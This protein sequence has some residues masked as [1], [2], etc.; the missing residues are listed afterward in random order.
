MKSKNISVSLEYHQNSPEFLDGSTVPELDTDVSCRNPDGRECR[1]FCDLVLES[2]P[3]QVRHTF[4]DLLR[5]FLLRKIRIVLAATHPV[6]ECRWRN[7]QASADLAL[8]QAGCLTG[9]HC[10]P[11]EVFRIFVVH[12]FFS[13]HNH[14]QN[15]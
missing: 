5:S 11:F 9:N 6:V 14:H 2:D 15:R 3:D 8:R 4:L 10:L 1:L 13:M 7:P 12:G